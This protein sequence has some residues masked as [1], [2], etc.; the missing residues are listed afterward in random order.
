L[1]FS[2]DKSPELEFIEDGDWACR[3]MRLSYTEVYDRFYDKM[4]DKQLNEL[5]AIINQ[6]PQSYTTD[7]NMIDDFNHIKMRIVD[8]P[9]YDFRARNTVNVWHA[10]WKSFKKISY[11]YY[12]DEN[13]DQQQTIVD[14]NYTPNGTEEK[15]EPDWIIEVWEGYRIGHELYVGCQ[16]LEYQHVSIDNPNS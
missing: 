14:E 15:V 4:S 16:P 7:K 3:R 13:G 5:L 1:F 8:N 10:C 12:K 2:F 6:S 9:T 11:V